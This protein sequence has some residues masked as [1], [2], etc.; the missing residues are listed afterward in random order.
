M[1]QLNAK[2]L[3]AGLSRRGLM[4]QLTSM[5]RPAMGLGAIYRGSFARADLRAPSALRP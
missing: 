2:L 1:R 3:E 5:V 4:E